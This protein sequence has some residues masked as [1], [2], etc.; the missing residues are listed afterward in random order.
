MN[1]QCGEPK[2]NYILEVTVDKAGFLRGDPAS[3]W[4]QK[5]PLQTGQPG[6]VEFYAI[7]AKLTTFEG[8][9][10]Q[11]SPKG[12]G[13]AEEKE[14]GQSQTP[15][16]VKSHSTWSAQEQ[17]V[18]GPTCQHLI[19][20]ASHMLLLPEASRVSEEITTDC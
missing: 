5:V 6:D 4:R 18:W 3:K 16:K 11:L 12:G 17:E 9:F 1:W 7:C 19:C 15:E 13:H 14:E 10:L 8:N 2:P 20:L